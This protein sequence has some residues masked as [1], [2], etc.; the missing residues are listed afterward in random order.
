MLSNKKYLII[1]VL[2]IYCIYIKTKESCYFWLRGRLNFILQ[3]YDAAF[4]ITYSW[5]NSMNI[6]LI[7]SCYQHGYPWPSLATPTNR[8]IASS[9]VQDYIPYRHRAAVGRFQLVVLPMKRSTGVHH[10]WARPCFSSCVPH[11]LVRLTLI[12]FVMGGMW[13][14][15]CYFVGFCL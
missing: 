15:D 13:P 9:R 6:F 11:V 1:S 3:I 12:V 8:L 4:Y 14:Y 2:I 7:I 10:L 5:I